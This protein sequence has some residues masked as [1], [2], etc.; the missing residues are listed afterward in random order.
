MGGRSELSSTTID[1]LERLERLCG[2]KVTGPAAYFSTRGMILQGV[3]I[4]KGNRKAR[5]VLCGGELVAIQTTGG[6]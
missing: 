6:E 5:A 4:E 2:W 3:P 1:E